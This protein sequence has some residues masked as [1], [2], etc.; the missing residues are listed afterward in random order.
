[1][2]VAIN[3]CV[4]PSRRLQ[5]QI[6]VPGDKSI[7]HR[8]IML[9]A[10]AEGETHAEG[11]LEGADALST[12]AA[13][14][15]MGVTIKGPHFGKISIQGVGLK[16]LQAPSQFLDCGNSG[17]TMR[18]MSGLLVGQSFSSILMGDET[19]MRRPMRRVVEPLTSMGAD[20]HAEPNGCAPL[21]IGPSSSLKGIRYAMKQASAQVKS[22]L[23]MAGL[24]AE[25]ET[26]V[27]ESD[28][29]RDH[30]ER[31]LT[32][33]GADIRTQGK[34]IT[35]K[36]LMNKVLQPL[37]LM[38]P[39]DFSSA[40]FWLVA[41]SIAP[42]PQS[43]IL[44]QNVGMN[45]SRNGAI[46]ILQLMGANIEIINPRIAGGEP[47]ADL[48]VRPA[49]LKGIRIPEKLVSLSIDEFPALFIAAASA[50]GMTKLTGAEELRVKE[51]DRLKSMADGL[52]KIGINHELLDDGI[53]IE[54]QDTWQG[55]STIA[56]GGG[57]VT[58]G[59]HRIAMSFAIASLRANEDIHIRDCLNVTTSYPTFVEHAL[60]LGLNIRH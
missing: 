19:L 15:A 21:R 17:T 29:T 59:D 51:S 16:G 32:R 33:M 34:E 39:G 60:Q 42:D 49:P 27:I 12:I 52:A 22:A 47:V 53:I 1:M 7:S 26:T 23:L 28:I 20:I 30:T 5:G 4:S 54:G 37:T 6:L 11:F 41:G 10:L 58:H 55:T 2:T 48:R 57:I 31:M 45:P 13:F 14:R 40:T 3:Y 44:L 50:D 35:V 38:I 43:N 25:G 56:N 8:T 36:P 9:G 46:N 18:L 24:Y